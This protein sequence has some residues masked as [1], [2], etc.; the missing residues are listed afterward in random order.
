LGQDFINKFAAEKYFMEEANEV[1]QLIQAMQLPLTLHQ[2]RIIGKALYRK[3][4]SITDLADD[5]K[6][7]FLKNADLKRLAALKIID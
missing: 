6:D 4:I 3:Q 2:R 1:L 5:V 7:A